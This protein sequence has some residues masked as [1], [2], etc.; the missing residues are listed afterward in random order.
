MKFNVEFASQVIDFPIIS[1]GILIILCLKTVALRR[2]FLKSNIFLLLV[3]TTL[4]VSGNL[5][6]I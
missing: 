3:I 4:L 6:K 5:K 2:D 1:K